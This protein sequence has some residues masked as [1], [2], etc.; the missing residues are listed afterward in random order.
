MGASEIEYARNGEVSIAYQTVGEGPLDLAL[1]GGFVG[2]LE[3]MWESPPAARF[4]ERLASFSRV[5][6]WDKRE[7][8]LSDRLGQP[9]TLEQGMEDLLCVLDRVGSERRWLLGCLRRPR[10]GR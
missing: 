6:L 7:Q 5:I 10:S 3:I 9:P 1:I 2:H 8:G 4:L